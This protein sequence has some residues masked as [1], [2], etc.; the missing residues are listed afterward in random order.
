MSLKAAKISFTDHFFHGIPTDAREL[1]LSGV[2]IRYIL[3][4]TAHSWSNT[5][6]IKCG[7]VIGCQRTC[8]CDFDLDLLT[9]L[10]KTKL[11]ESGCNKDVLTRTAAGMSVGG[12]FRYVTFYRIKGFRTSRTDRQSKK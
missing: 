9:Y 3:F 10:I 5:L 8:L 2:S 4:K 1:T 12:Y 7:I 11:R 6:T